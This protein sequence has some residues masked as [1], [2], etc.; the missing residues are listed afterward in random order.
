MNTFNFRTLSFALALVAMLA[1]AGSAMAADACC[2]PD[3]LSPEKQEIAKKLYD[4][5]YN[6]TKGLRKELKAKRHELGAQMHSQNPD[7]KKIQELATAVSDLRAKLYSARIAL[8]SKLIQEGIS[9]GDYGKGKGKR[10][11]FG[12]CDGGGAGRGC[13]G[14]P[15][16]Q[17]G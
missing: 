10:R 5:F 17:G 12:P 4:D 16:I 13:G 9:T 14:C 3:N 7:E 11:G 15:G 2:E 1:L 8:K 6:N